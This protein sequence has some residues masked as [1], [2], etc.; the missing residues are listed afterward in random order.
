MFVHGVTD[1]VGMSH[2]SSVDLYRVFRRHACYEL[3][4]SETET[5][6]NVSDPPM[7]TLTSARQ[8]DVDETLSQVLHSF[9]FVK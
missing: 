4:L 6:L 5:N 7:K 9:R 1:E 3:R 2:S 8:K